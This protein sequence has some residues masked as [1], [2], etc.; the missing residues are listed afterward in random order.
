LVINTL[1]MVVLWSC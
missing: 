1:L